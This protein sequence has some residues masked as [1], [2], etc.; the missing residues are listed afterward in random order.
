MEHS[1]F[2]GLQPPPPSLWKL[3]GVPN[4]LRPRARVF[5]LTMSKWT[6][7]LKCP[8]LTFAVGVPQVRQLLGERLQRMQL[9]P[10]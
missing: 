7:P 8:R 5:A 10:L 2:L 1:T 4:P 6:L 3:L 9:G